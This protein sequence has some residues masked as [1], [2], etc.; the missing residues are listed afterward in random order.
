[1]NQKLFTRFY[2]DKEKD[3]I[4]NLYKEKE[5]ELTYILETPN[6]NTGN[7]ITNLARL[8]K[9]QL[10]KNE[11]D[12]K[13][14]K[15]TIP[16]SINGD[17]EIVYI[18][19]LGGFKIANIFENGKIEL[20]AKIPAI[21]KT[22]MSQTKEYDLPIEKTI[23]KSYILKKSKFKTDLHT[24]MNANL[25][26][27][28]L[29]AL[30]IANQIKYPLYYIKKLNL[31]MS[32]S[33]EE[34]ILKQRENVEKQFKD[35]KLTGKYLTRK[36]DDNT[37]INFADFILNNKENAE[38][39]ISKIRTSLSILKD[40]QAVFTNL[41]KLYLYRYVFAR[42]I[43][44]TEKIEIRKEK[45]DKIP[46]KNIRSIVKQM[47]KDKEEGSQYQNNTLFEDKLLW[48]AREYKKQGIEYVEITDTNLAKKGKAGIRVIEQMHNIMPKIEKE[49]GV[50][51]RL[52][53]GIRRIPLTIIKD[54]QQNENYLRE[55]LDVLKAIAKSP[56]VAGSDFI[57]E[58]IN[59]INELQPVINEI[60]RYVVEEDPNFT[61]RI[62]AGEN[63]SLRDN[64]ENSIDCIL[65]SLK[66]G[67]KIPN[68]RLGHGL[69]TTDLN[70]ENGKKLIEKMQKTGAVLE[71]QLT[72]NVRLNN[73]SNLQKHPIKTY[74]KNNIKCV[75]GTDGCGMYGTDTID[76]QLALQNLLG[77]TDNDFKEM[78]KV[79]DEII[80]RSH[81]YF[82][83][84]SKAFEKF[85]NGRNIE[86]AI[87]EEELKNEIKNKNKKMNLRIKEGILSEDALKEKIKDLPTDKVPI[88]IAGGSFNAEG[89]E[90]MLTEAGRKILTELI[91]K[92][93]DQKAY[94]V[95]GHKMQGYEKAIV[96]ISRDLN[97]KFEIDAIIPKVITENVKNNLLKENIDGI[98]ISTENEDS[99][100]YKS[101]NYE[102]FERRSSVVLAFDG[103]SPVSNLVQEAKNG[104]G[105]S[106]I[107][108]NAENSSLNEKAKS[109]NGYVTAFNLNQD[110]VNKILQDIPEIKEDEKIKKYEI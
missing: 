48:I 68:F 91:E 83:E 24:H 14:I 35:C 30:G 108:V 11:N 19:R 9:V 44:D 86:E 41:E 25:T 31:K 8:C 37:F 77:L 53:V 17:N 107:Y 71:F 52:L 42:G 18:F 104:K 33:Q 21:S 54:E 74:L 110:I 57:G 61:I 3:I 65:N 89:R 102:I 55:T 88:I 12:M 96:D 87:M 94:F 51:I 82:I 106:K 4:V 60:V 109:L 105:K 80:E 90:T 28:C 76:E 13:I 38:Y 100:I 79:E 26:P 63:D 98:R 2:L 62:H 103:N 92:V 40:G 84:K 46:D 99:G 101:F 50:K 32:K 81:K 20:K 6:H 75:Q 10:S 67:E 58:E 59:S 29:I 64:V 49:T 97:K 27:D 39:N 69:Y 47:L 22:L 66:P 5:D 7:L 70:S 78:K 73:L 93:N 95:I 43:R 56:Y 16:A 34:K 72:S 1:M 45:I 36:I 23:V 15:G 85:L